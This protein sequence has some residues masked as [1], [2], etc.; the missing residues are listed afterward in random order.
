MRVLIPLGIFCPL[1]FWAVLR[2]PAPFTS[3]F[4]TYSDV[5]DT[6]TQRSAG[7][8]YLD[9]VHDKVITGLNITNAVKHCIRLTNCYNIVIRNCR[10]SFSKGNGIDL[11]GCKNITII[12]CYM[13]SV[14]T[15]VYV[16][17]S[18]GINV[19][20][21]ETKNV[22]GPFPRGQMVQF[23][24]VNGTGNRVNYNTCEN[25]LG[26]SYPED[27]INMYKSNGTPADP[28][29]I[30]GNRI[31]GGGPSKTGGGIMLGDNGGSYQVAK[32]NILVNPG[33]YGMAISSGNHIQIIN[34]KI[35]GR[36]QPF[37]NVGL[38]IWN[39]Y[40]SGCSLNTISGNQVNWTMASGEV[41]PCWNNGNCG[42]VA[43][44]ATNVCG[45]N[46][47]EDLLPAKV[48]TK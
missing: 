15:G 47:D 35:F 5:N 12:N 38:Y 48:L 18:E 4:H 10:L 9:G 37:S 44:W 26:K 2:G 20:H 36:Q 46:I 22:T 3:I 8:L 31:R 21:N 33:Q 41:N 17:E 11:S 34:N 42:D 45:A 14:S 19:E 25:I 6:I 39:Q 7:P 13:E 28:I 24:N 23:N 43:G 29:Q 27:A 32:D 1:L 30:I 40:K 16:L